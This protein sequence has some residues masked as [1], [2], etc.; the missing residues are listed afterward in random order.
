MILS[1][2]RRTDVPRF[3]MEWFLQ[4]LREGYADVRN[5]M[6]PRRV[7]RVPLTKET[8]DAVVFWTKDPKG[9]LA[10][11]EEIPF[12]Y[13]VQ[14]TL[15]DYGPEVEPNLPTVGERVESFQ[16]L[17]EK[18]GP[19]RVIWRYD[20]ILFN[21]KCTPEE[22]LRRFEKLASALRGSTDQVVISFLDLY[23]KIQ[24]R[25]APLKAMELPEEE[26]RLFAGELARLAKA[27][28]MRITTCAET[29]D[30][31]AQ[32]VEPGC[33]I[34][35]NRLEQLLE[36]PLKLSKD[37]NQRP[38]CGCVESVDIG[39]YNTCLHGCRYCYA[40]GSDA[41]VAR[42]AGQYDVF[43]TML[44]GKVGEEDTVTVRKL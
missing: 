1:V 19:H 44:C 25:I 29:I 6:N 7:S 3:Y 42:T 38:A 8:V 5:P 24:K 33:C 27:N 2:S 26:L 12:P 30:L 32:G 14:F 16:K 28:G 41:L 40:N 34:D 37:K 18:L 31:R 15:N 13:Y 36:R 35:K 23:P 4:R 22:H 11:G 17:A 20:P 9:L 43:S 21:E 10:H 39:A